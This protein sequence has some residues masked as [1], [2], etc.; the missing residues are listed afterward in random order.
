M[1]ISAHHPGRVRL[2]AGSGGVD[3]GV[4]I[5][6]AA[7][8]PA[9]MPTLPLDPSQQEA[10]IRTTPPVEDPV[11]VA[12]VKEYPIILHLTQVKMSQ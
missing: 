3:F 10:A 12:F 1:V 8:A 7:V 6:T 4:P 11:I 5:S 2:R 9:V